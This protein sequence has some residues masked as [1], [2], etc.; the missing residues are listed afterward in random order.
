[1]RFWC[2]LFG[3]SVKRNPAEDYFESE[4]Y[5]SPSGE[6][7]GLSATG[8]LG[9]LTP[10]QEEFIAQVEEQYP[11]IV[12][13]IIPDIENRFQYWKPEF[14]ISD[15][16]QEFKPVYLDIPTCEQQPVEWE[17]AFETVH[18]RNHTVFV[19]MLDFQPQYVRIDG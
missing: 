18:D 11:L 14:K 17:I 2:S 13:A 6:M 10:R 12:A 9:S 1:M 8:E 5:F 16:K 7:M 4:R 3:K 19:V 15:F